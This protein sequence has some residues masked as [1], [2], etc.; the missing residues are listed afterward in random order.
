MPVTND[1]SDD[2][3]EP[4]PSFDKFVYL[5]QLIA[6]SRKLFPSTTFDQGQA[7]VLLKKAFD[8]VKS[9]FTI[10]DAVN[11]AN[12]FALPETAI[13]NDAALF[14]V[15]GY[16]LPAFVRWKQ[17]Q[18]THTRMSVQRLRDRWDPTD[19][20]FDMLL[21]IA[22]GGVPVMVGRDFVPNRR[23]PHG[24]SPNYIIAHTAVN[25]LIYDSYVNNLAIILPSD[26]VALIPEDIP[27]HMS[28]L[29]H[30]LKKGKPQG[31][32]TCNYS[33][34]KFPSQLNTEEVR[35]MS[36][37][38][39]GNIQLPTVNDLAEM[40]LAQVDRA[41]ATGRDLRDLRLWK[42]D[43]KGA[44]TLLFFKPR[45][46]GLLA[47]PMTPDACRIFQRLLRK[48]LVYIPIAGN[49]GMTQFPFVFYVISRSLYRRIQHLLKG[50]CKIYIDDLMGICFD[51]EVDRD[52]ATA[53]CGIEDLLGDD[54]IAN[55][56]TDTG[57]ALDW[58]GWRFDLDT[59]SVSVADHN[60][61]KT[62]YGFL[63]VAK[64]QRIQVRNLHT[65][66]SWASRYALI[67]PFMSP[68]SGY[69][70]TAFSGYHN[71]EAYIA[72]PDSAYL[73][74][75]LWRIFFFL[76]K[77]EPVSFTRPIE[78]FRPI[79]PRAQYLL[80]VDGCPGGIGCLIL[81]R[82]RDGRWSKW[83]AFSWCGEY[84]LG[85]ESRYQNSMEF[86]SAVMGLACLAW[87]GVSDAQ[88]EVLGDNTASLCW[89]SSMNFRPGSSTSA[90]IAY[91]LLQKVVGLRVV[92]TVFR[93]GVLNHRADALSRGASP[94]DF[95]F[96]AHN[97][98][99]R[100]SAPSVLREFS[101][102]LDPSLNYMDE[103]SLYD[104]W[105]HYNRIISKLMS[106]TRL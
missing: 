64:G 11:W 13:R 7:L 29:G 6:V 55:D 14:K 40:V 34:G 45:D 67:C 59:M 94:S 104:C 52:I 69:L 23:E 36:R 49:F 100:S 93:A 47:M 48:G 43:L 81:R 5:D 70:Y 106:S 46:C 10:H 15:M 37:E 32:V 19:P 68:F 30:T 61:Y 83:F 74:V 24:F 97:S 89:M 84:S 27:L 42:M 77:L 80:E 101:S 90:A 21:E 91:M 22:D 62:L 86:I 51:D 78:S 71:L 57:R 28:R 25:K 88:V 16:D 85:N 3:S 53:S 99:V 76:M 103:G 98:F 65:L 82:G 96:P 1:R 79:K 17:S 31:R 105:G 2:I 33:Y 54:A 20:D 50:A 4:L 39:Y 63:C 56:K 60:Y 58:I 38:Y 12:G 41:S 95:Y 73:V 35:T 92:S 44:F 18:I 102:L 8:S 26:S 75:V 9:N 72:L 66:A 87:L